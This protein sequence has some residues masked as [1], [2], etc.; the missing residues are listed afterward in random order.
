MND[1]R[2]EK[3]YGRAIA[4]RAAQSEPCDI[5]PEAMLDLL[6]GRVPEAQ[7]R[8]LL[9]EIQRRP[10]CQEEFAL[11]GAVVRASREVQVPRRTRWALPVAAAAVLTLAVALIWRPWQGAPEPVLRSGGTTIAAITPSGSVSADAPRSLVW[12]P[13]AGGWRY[14][15]AVV[16]STGQALFR[17]E[18]ADTTLAIPES[19]WPAPGVTHRWWVRGRLPGGETVR[20]ELTPFS[21]PR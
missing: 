18:T 19:A 1:D 9:E 10:A 13:L 7:R 15:V 3:L 17:G 20:S 11:L 5:P 8:R 14:E 2:L 21:A 4:R 16:D 12:H 6:E